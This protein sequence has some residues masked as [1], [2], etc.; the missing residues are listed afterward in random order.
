M[1][2][3]HQTDQ[4]EGK[5]AGEEGARQVGIA[6]TAKEEKLAMMAVLKGKVEARQNMFNHVKQK[7]D[8]THATVM[9]CME[10]VEGEAKERF[11][12][13]EEFEEEI[14]KLSD[15]MS[16]HSLVCTI[17]RLKKDSGQDGGGGED[18]G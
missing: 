5:G 7:G 3:G 18:S 14:I 1:R 2:G 12:V 4:T 10:R 11:G 8:L 6:T 9:D 15:K 17:T 16:Q 13:V